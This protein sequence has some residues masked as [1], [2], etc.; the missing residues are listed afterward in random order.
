MDRRDFLRSA[1]FVIASTLALGSWA[2]AR[3]ARIQPVAANT[4]R[5]FR[6]GV[7]SADPQPDA[8]LLWTKIVPLNP[9]ADERLHV[10]LSRH[11]DFR[12]VQ[13][14]RRIIAQLA[15]DHSVRAL[16]T[17]L[18]PDTIYFYRFIAADGAV[19]RTGRTWTAP[20]PS[21]TRPVLIAVASCQS[22]PASQYGS[23]RHLI[24]R[25]QKTGE[26]PDFVLHLGDYVYGSTRSL[27]VDPAT[28]LS[29]PD[30]EAMPLGRPGAANA[31][32]A[33]SRGA[34]AAQN[35]TADP[36]AGIYEFE[37]ALAAVR[38]LYDKY[39][40]DRDLQDARA[41]FPFV[42]IWD[43]HEFGNDVWQSFS[44]EGSNPAGRMAATQAWSEWVPQI[45]S[46][47]QS[48]P[49]VPNQ[50][51]D[52]VR[53]L[54]RQEQISDFDDNFL[55]RNAQNL[56]SIM[57]MTGYR[58]V[59]WGQMVDLIITDNR[60]YRG[61]GA[62]PAISMAS[63]AGDQ[64]ADG[65]FTGFRLY[66]GGVLNTLAE[67]R[68]ANGGKPP[69]TIT[70]NGK[71]TANPRADAPR[72]SLLGA[73]QKAWFK[74]ALSQ[75]RARWKVW[76]NAEPIT[77]FQWDIGKLKPEIGSGFNWLDSWDGFPNE[78]RELLQFIRKNN[79]AN[80]VALSGDRHAQ[81][82]A[83]VADDYA[84]EA[85]DYVIPEFTCTG[86]SA[87]PRAR[88]L[89]NVFQRLGIGE[90]ARARLGGTGRP[91]CTLDATLT[92]GVEATKAL[93]DGASQETVAELAKRSPNPEM[94]FCDMDSHGYLLARFSD[95]AVDVEFVTMPRE[96]WSTDQQPDGPPALRQVKFQTPAWN[97][98]ERPVIK[99]VSQT[100]E[101]TVGR[102]G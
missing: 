74:T 79:I 36:A 40:L 77:G 13:V 82:A 99:L 25:E 69:A 19:S 30:P 35:P 9:K 11:A 63:I 4:R 12:D 97:P 33:G 96:I 92:L 89:S 20:S 73:K 53:A 7:A 60:S 78:R 102:A 55:A 32:G 34:R 50:A 95:T 56:A 39:H 26:R 68:F 57:A 8:I 47:N 93:I 86:I 100:G 42:T 45:L 44:G 90:F 1:S 80:V 61:P 29:G 59:R 23:Y 91:A 75:S 85:P 87:F 46:A 64:A 17:G 5:A 94:A 62:N 27:P 21:S 81:F 84:S 101:R 18:A 24:Q 14:E 83:C 41:L 31:P 51:R 37:P 58:A 52:Y 98:A 15:S 71:T 65:I 28:G 16:V 22:Y 43:D 6:W 49:N 48:I 72:V 70:I 2:H 88:N 66:E 76:A 3:P 54:V 10:Q 67:G 38:A